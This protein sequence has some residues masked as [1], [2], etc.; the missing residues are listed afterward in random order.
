M[1][2]PASVVSP[3]ASWRLIDVLHRGKAE[4]DAVALGMWNGSPVLAMRW[5][6]SKDAPLGNPQSRGLPTWFILPEWSYVPLLKS[7]KIKDDKARM[8][9]AV[10]GVP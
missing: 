5:N 7:G 8:A 4:D 6:G 1:I 2:E 3:K 9:C 10:L